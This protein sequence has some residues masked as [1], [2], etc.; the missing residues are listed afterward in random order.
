MARAKKPR[1]AKKSSGCSSSHYY[2]AAAIVAAFASVF[3]LVRFGLWKSTTRN[4][5]AGVT[6]IM[7]NTSDTGEQRDSWVRQLAAHARWL[8]RTT[9]ESSV[10]APNTAEPAAPDA[11]EREALASTPEGVKPPRAIL[12]ATTTCHVARHGREYWRSGTG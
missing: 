4:P 7:P 10:A 6:L 9:G 2:A 3:A 5:F 12:N 11:V 1:T 8:N